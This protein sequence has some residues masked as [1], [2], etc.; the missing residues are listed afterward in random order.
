[1]KNIIKTYRPFLFSFISIL[2]IIIFHVYYS[3]G[4]FDEN[5]LTVISDVEAVIVKLGT[6]LALFWAAYRSRQHSSPNARAWLLLAIAQ[7]TNTIADIL[8]AV[9]EV[10]FNISPYPSTADIFYLLYYPLFFV[11]I[12]NFPTRKIQSLDWVKRTLDLVTMLIGAFAIFWNYILGPIFEHSQDLPTIERFLAFAYPIGDLI[13]L[14]AVLIIFYNRIHGESSGPIFLLTI[15]VFFM[16]IADFGFSVQTA[17]GTYVSGGLLD[18]GW[19]AQDLLFWIAALWQII[20]I[21][22]H[23]RQD[24]LSQSITELTNNLYSYYPLLWML[25]I[26]FMLYHRFFIELPMSAEQIGLIS[27]I[28]WCIVVIRQILTNVETRRLFARVESSLSTV[29]QQAEELEEANRV[30]GY[31]ISE[32]KKAEEQLAF[33]ALHDF[34][35]QL[36]NRGLFL[37]RLEMAIQRTRR[38]K[39][40]LYAVF[41]LDLD[42]FKHINDTK[43]HATGDELLKQV[44]E[45][46]R[47]CIR[48]S[49][50]VARLGGDEFI[51]LLECSTEDTTCQ[52]TANRIMEQLKH[53]FLIDG[54]NLYVSASI[55]IVDDIAKYDNSSDVLRD[56]DIAMYHAK[57]AGK[58]RFEVFTSEMRTQ[59]IE[60]VMIEN[61][62]RYAIEYHEFTLH[63]QPIFSLETDQIQG[64]EALI[65]WENPRLGMVLPANFIPIAEETGLIIDIGEWV[66]KEACTRMKT[67]HDQFPSFKQLFINVN[68][69]G[70]QF[71]QFDFIENL[72]GIL[73]E[74]RL[75]PGCLKLEITESVLL[76]SQQTES[77]FFNLL[78]EMGV[79]IQID[80]FGT[81]YSSLSYIQHIPV[82]VIK[83][84]RSFIQEVENGEKFVELIHAII[85][86]AHSLGMDTTAEGIETRNQ[87]E[88]LRSLGCNFAQGFYLGKPMD[89]NAT[90]NLLQIKEK[91]VQQK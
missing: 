85:R 86:M 80:D 4:S 25:A 42:Q 56:A 14:W 31:E 26:T 87:K 67:W 88:I 54:E 39:D 15:G 10:G 21:R 20:I 58:S 59:A 40:I 46:L 76:D 43:G 64:F 27:I 66:L 74:T 62:L 19:I 50:T 17:L 70:K 38:H 36:P 51:I 24:D 72:K 65:R 30:L 22:Q 79:H 57:G 81:G 37:D 7:V 48:A 89:S 53:P 11:A 63:Y 41:F 45:R 90:E 47:D 71:S 6:T 78:R 2:A 34:L 61:E 32:R 18:S 52:V 1:M 13:L 68:I 75:D 49:D 73:E 29:K 69:S 8:W 84:D 77:S 55:G 16:V 44:A 23:S 9:F 5:S 60:R 12:L 83:I 82:D 28:I 3:F 35:T 33:D 91:K